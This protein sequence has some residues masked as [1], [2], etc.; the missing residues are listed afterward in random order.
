LL[1]FNYQIMKKLIVLTLA[2]AFLMSGASFAKAVDTPSSTGDMESLELAKP[3][4]FGQTDPEVKKLQMYL[5]KHGY[6]KTTPTNF[7]GS[8]TRAAMKLLQEKMGLKS[9]GANIGPKTRELLKGLKGKGDLGKKVSTVPG[10][11]G[12][13]VFSPSSGLPC[14]GGSGKVAGGNPSDPDKGSG[15]GTPVDQKNPTDKGQGGDYRCLDG[16]GAVAL[17]ASLLPNPTGTPTYVVTHTGGVTN[18]AWLNFKL[19][20]PMDCPTVVSKMQVKVD[21]ND[22][23]SSW[24]PVQSV[25]LMHGSTQLATTQMMGGGGTTYLS[26]TVT[27][28]GPTTIGVGA[29]AGLEAGNMVKFDGSYMSGGMGYSWTASG[30]IT[31]IL[32]GS[33]MTVN[34]TTPAT[35][36]T[37]ATS[38]MGMIMVVGPRVLTFQLP[39]W[40]VTV[41]AHSSEDFAIVAN[42]QNVTT[43]AGAIAVS[44]TGA[45]TFTGTPT[46]FTLQLIEALNTSSMGGIVNDQTVPLT[47]PTTL[48]SPVINIYM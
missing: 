26:G 28:T 38:I 21:T 30:T 36:P 46:F 4:H 37:G 47:L 18:A 13:M 15:Y 1:L 32:T 8:K 40:A 27:A 48:I 12:D 29:T 42:S 39:A 45:T 33:T 23:T 20:N 31:A 11:L 41:G 35:I 24:P 44:A 17:T 6:L 25:K 3:L 43:T 2:T 14:D 5:V 9:D 34:I 10:C 7:Y 19:S 22:V 16:M